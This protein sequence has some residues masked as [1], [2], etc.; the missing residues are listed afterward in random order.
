MRDPD[1][2][3]RLGK[4]EDASRQT[5]VTVGNLRRST[6]IVLP[7]GRNVTLNFFVA[8]VYFVSSI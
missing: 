2:P 8:G 3:L 5:V 1:P 6:S 4:I 7:L